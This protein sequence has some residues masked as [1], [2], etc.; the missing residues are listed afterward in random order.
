MDSIEILLDYLV[1]GKPNYEGNEKE[2]EEYLRFGPEKRLKTFIS[3]SEEPYLNFK[4]Y[5]PRN[6]SEML[7]LTKKAIRKITSRLALM[8]SHRC[9]I[10]LSLRLPIIFFFCLS[11]SLCT[12]N[13][14]PIYL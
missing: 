4:N 3:L 7:P 6:K 1:K 8:C 2:V 9:L 12:F 14:S 13:T 10:K 11:I 5:L